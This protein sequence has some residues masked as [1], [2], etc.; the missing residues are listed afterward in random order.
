MKFLISYKIRYITFRILSIINLICK[1]DL[2][3]E[4]S[5]SRIKQI[6]NSLSY[7]IDHFFKIN[8]FSYYKKII[9]INSHLKAKKIKSKKLKYIVFCDDGFDHPD[10][11][12]REFVKKNDREL[13]YKRLYFFL[14]KLENTFQKKI[15]FCKHPRAKYPFSRSFLRIKNSFLVKIGTSEKDI[16]SSFLFLI[17]ST[18]MISKA[19]LFKK[20]VIVLKSSLLGY[21]INL[22]I[23]E[24]IN[25]IKLPVI[26]IDDYN[27]IDIKKKILNINKKHIK[28]FIFKN[29]FLK[30][31]KT[32][33]VII[34][35]YISRLKV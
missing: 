20:K 33:A 14:K 26:N 31:K 27:V 4:S 19:I 23:N 10:R 15:I 35:N 17:N 8:I 11:T 16:L 2:C 30:S 34:K 1:F 32:N 22:R 5:E 29:I 13:Y 6:Q 12:I 9:R 25:E 7:K 28:N 18:S 24:M 3:F 21:F